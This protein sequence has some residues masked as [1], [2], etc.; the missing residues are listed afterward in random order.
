MGW[1]VVRVSPWHLA[2]FYVDEQEARRKGVELGEQYLVRYGSKEIAT[3]SFT[4]ESP[5]GAPDA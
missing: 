2:G 5:R 3:D 4:W 1:A